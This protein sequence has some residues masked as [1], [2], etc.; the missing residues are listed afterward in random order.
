MRIKNICSAPS[1]K[2][3]LPLGATRRRD[4]TGFIEFKRGEIKE[5]EDARGII[6]AYPGKFELVK[7]EKKVAKKKA[8]KVTKKKVK[9]A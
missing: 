2:V 8:K 3:A 6:E 1:A 5:V 4:I 7:S 9:K